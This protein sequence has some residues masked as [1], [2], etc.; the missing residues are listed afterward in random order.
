MTRDGMVNKIEL[1][2]ANVSQKH[3]MAVALC[4]YTSVDTIVSKLRQDKYKTRE[5]IVGTMKK[6]AAEDDIEVG[7]STLSLR[8]PLSYTRIQAPC[9]SVHCSHTQC[10][11]ASFYFMSNEQSPTWT[12]P[13]CSK[14][15]RPEDLFIDGYFD[16]I[17][18]RVPEDEDNV[19][20]DPDGSWHTRD[21]KVT[22]SSKAIPPAAKASLADTTG[23]AG[24]TKAEAPSPQL[25]TKQER[26]PSASDLPPAT[27]TPSV[28]PQNGIPPSAEIVTLED[29]PTP[30]PASARLTTSHS[31]S[32]NG[33]SGSSSH[34][35]VELGTPTGLS[36]PSAAGPPRSTAL[37]SRGQSAHEAIDLTLSDS[38]DEPPSPPP[39]TRRPPTQPSTAAIRAG[40]ALSGGGSSS[41]GSN[42][43]R[44]FGMPPPEVR[45]AM[46]H[47]LPANG[48]LHHS[49]HNDLRPATA[50]PV[51]SHGF[52]QWAN[53]SNVPSTSRPSLPQQSSFS[54]GMT[55]ADAYARPF[56]GQ[57]GWPPSRSQDQRAPINGAPLAS[58]SSS[59]TSAATATAPPAPAE[60]SSFGARLARFRQANGSQEPTAPL[61]PPPP[62]AT[63]TSI[64]SSATSSRNHAS[65]PNSSSATL[66]IRNGAPASSS[67]VRARDTDDD[68]EEDATTLAPASKRLRRT[69]SS[70]AQRPKESSP[71]PVVN[72]AST[73]TGSATADAS[74][75][76]TPLPSVSPS[77][78]PSAQRRQPRRSGA[79]VNYDE[80]D[81][82][83]DE[84]D[85][86]DDDEPV[87]G[88]RRARP[89]AG[90]G[91]SSMDS[92]SGEQSADQEFDELSD[93][94]E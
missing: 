93:S 27:P 6:A 58:S 53:S 92:T 30:P 46:A 13:H 48:V 14:T 79:P 61:W 91:N 16:D 78:P 5:E 66:E 74:R 57:A 28:A 3:V 45:S 43:S 82:E 65:S 8:D 64:S 87:R 4:S 18:K 50:S 63:N 69:D 37:S 62:A 23:V 47:G 94:G 34:A 52:S 84:A 10:F 22:S 68:A 20:V 54:A 36:A 7:T 1:V 73:S 49:P 41:S 44:A 33:A 59:S 12:C 9:R 42:L 60:T 19:E 31:E 21:G 15:L 71:A 51:T 72:G 88:P 55:A 83:E 81:D 76:S 85:D 17:L 86:E 40:Q 35:P 90:A 67:A 80:Q 24:A 32:T 56:P 70:E 25:V 11:D 39:P 77:P 89:A 75:V 26:D 38:D 29:S 2:Y